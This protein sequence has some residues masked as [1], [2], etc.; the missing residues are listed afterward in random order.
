MH[1]ENL[2]ELVD[3]FIAKWVVTFH[4][5]DDDILCFNV[6]RILAIGACLEDTFK[7]GVLLFHELV[8]Q[9]NA[10]SGTESL[11]GNSINRTLASLVLDVVRGLNVILGKVDK[12]HVEVRPRGEFSMTTFAWINLIAG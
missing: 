5:S 8:D 12:L 2:G 9:G 11:V 3:R 4:G 6:V 10:R 7:V 1:S